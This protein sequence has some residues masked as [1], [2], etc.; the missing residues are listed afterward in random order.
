MELQP[1]R[2]TFT[3]VGQNVDAKLYFRHKDTQ[4]LEVHVHCYNWP[5]RVP[6]LSLIQE[7]HC[8]VCVCVFLSTFVIRVLYSC[9]W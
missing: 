9:T 7:N 2:N 5:E 4:D 6:Q 3:L 8:F 1:S